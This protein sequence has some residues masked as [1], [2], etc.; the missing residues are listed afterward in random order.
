MNT[1]AAHHFAEEH[2]P[3]AWSVEPA[4][5][6]DPVHPRMPNR[7]TVAA[8]L[9]DRDGTLVEDVPHNGDPDR[10]RLLPGAREAVALL[11]TAG[12]PTG[13]VSDQPGIGRGLLT[14]ADVCRV[15]DRVDALLGGLG[16]FVYCPHL[17]EAG[18]PCRK[19]R[20]GLILEAAR[21]LGV[22]PRH[23]VVIGGIEAD[24]LAARA[25]GARAVL[26]SDPATDLLA[27]VRRILTA[28]R[29][30]PS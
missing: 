9:F 23:C 17:P 2:T 15:D 6:E 1:P 11:R 19:P 13:V 27:A 29:G 22:D 7:T 14:D 16:T 3:D 5:V 8:V 30:A 20:P 12:I 24:V 10:V 21:R 4:A 25:A 18:C 26:V 28:E